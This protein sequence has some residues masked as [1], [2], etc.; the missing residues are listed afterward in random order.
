MAKYNIPA[1]VMGGLERDHC[2][3]YTNVD[4]K[5]YNFGSR[6]FFG[7]LRYAVPYLCLIHVGYLLTL[8]STKDFTHAQDGTPVDTPRGRHHVESFVLTADNITIR[9]LPWIQ[10]NKKGKSTTYLVLSYERINHAHPFCRC[11]FV[12]G[13]SYE[14][15]TSSIGLLNVLQLLCAK[16]Y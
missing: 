10:S 13:L 3:A 16:S 6:F 12:K 11:D 8:H 15:T 4:L 14:C 9:S 1:S 7:K 5:K 2:G